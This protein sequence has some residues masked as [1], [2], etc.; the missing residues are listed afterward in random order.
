MPLADDFYFIVHDVGNGRL[1]LNAR[2]AGLGLAGALV[3]E[4]ILNKNLHVAS[5][6][7]SLTGADPPDDDL[8]YRILRQLSADQHNRS[9][10]T[11]LAYLSQGAV[12]RVAVRLTRAGQIEPETSR[13]L[14]RNSVRYLPVDPKVAAWPTDRLYGKVDRG[15][16][17]DFGD[18]MLAGLVAVTGFTKQVWWDGDAVTMRHIAAAVGS[19]PMSLREVLAHT[20]AAVGDATLSPHR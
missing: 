6:T 4:L 3:G 1:R 8:G 20:E 17:L 18:A 2:A 5:G 12:E 16:P 11:W 13:R 14:W 19:L 10:R 9:L 7:L 15:D